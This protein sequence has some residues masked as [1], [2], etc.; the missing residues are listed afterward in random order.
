[1]ISYNVYWIAVITGFFVL[2]FREKRGHR[3][4]SKD[5][6]QGSPQ[7]SGSG[8]VVLESEVGMIEKT[9]PATSDSEVRRVSS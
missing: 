4:F 1:M 9:V 6:K 3:L 8:E 7:P 5:T 2:K